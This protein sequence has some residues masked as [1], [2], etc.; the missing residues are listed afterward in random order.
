MLILHSPQIVQEKIKRWKQ[1][2]KIALVPTMGCL[3]EGHLSL[4]RM[5]RSYAQ[6]VIVSI[7]VNP[8]Q[9][10]PHEDYERYPKTFE[11]D[12]E[13]LRSLEVDLVFHPSVEDLYPKGFSTRVSVG[14]LSSTLCGRSRFGHFDGVATICLKLFEITQSDF[15]IFG[16]KDF[17]QLRVIQQL[18][19]DLNLPISILAHEVVRDPDG[20]ALSSRNSYLSESQRIVARRIPQFIHWAR[21]F[22]RDQPDVTVDRIL[23]GTKE[24]LTV[25]ELE[26]DYVEVASE[27]DL[28][29]TPPTTRIADIFRPRLFVAARIGETRLIDNMSLSIEK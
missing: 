26:I 29:P 13:K 2:S 12:S 27:K 20:V 9:F 24:H 8:L 6:K 7:F 28:T 21:D 10:G 11:A 14:S 25:P 1:E 3:H 4:I 5:A 19:G 17:Q 18:C 16:E 15:A 22:S 23:K